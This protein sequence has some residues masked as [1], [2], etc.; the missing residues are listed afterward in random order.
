VGVKRPVVITIAVA[1]LV[2]GAALAWFEVR[3]EREFRRL[4]AVGDA[5]LAG[6]RTSE[7]IEAFSGAVVLKQEAMI[8]Y[9]KRGDTYLQRGEL[10]AA[11][12]DLRVAVT[13][14][15]TAPRPL[16]RLGD[17]YLAQQQLRAAA[18][19]YQQSL[20]LE[21][22]A[23][24]VL[25]KLGLAHYRAADYTKA[26]DALRRSLAL[27][28]TAVEPHYLLGMTLRA[29][30]QFDEALRTLRHAT[31]IAPAFAPAREEQANLLWDL[32]RRRES[33]EQ[34]EALAAL[35]P[36][37]PARLVS[38]GLAYARLG[39]PEAAIVTLGRAAERDPANAMVTTAMGRV[40]LDM[41]EAGQDGTALDK[42][43]D[44]LQRAAAFPEASSETLTLYGRALLLS[45]NAAT[46]ERVLQQAAT[47]LPIDPLAFRYLADA[48]ARL[49]HAAAAREAEERYAR[50]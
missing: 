4:I 44:A 11:I 31:T 37:R 26:A 50:F 15:P 49:G 18:E 41:A 47:R 8:A 40:W 42:A 2:A 16:E 1:A 20:N 14:D 39:R 5:D 25:Y 24:R 28:G 23:P 30:Q 43:I 22:R 3:Q 33:L 7:A 38:V 12:R 13:L 10:A 48:A 46:A 21:D 32:G 36:A 9:L 29:Q 27:D 34:L 35:E 45:R 17:A 19:Q 6:G